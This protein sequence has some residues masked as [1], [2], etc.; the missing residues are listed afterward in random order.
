MAMP[1]FMTTHI[2]RFNLRLFPA[3]YLLQGRYKIPCK[4]ASPAATFL[5]CPA[6]YTLWAR[7][8]IVKQLTNRRSSRYRV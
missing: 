1:W 5:I 4:T 8:V 7:G 2:K 3:G 6:Q